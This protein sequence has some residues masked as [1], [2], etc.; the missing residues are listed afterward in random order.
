MVDTA[1]ILAGGRG[2]RLFP[3][4][5]DRPKALVPLMDRPLISWIILWLKKN[6]IKK[7]I[8]S[9]DYKKEVLMDYLGDGKRFGVNIVYN[10]HK[11]AKDTGDAFRNVFSNV[12]LPQT[13][14]AMNSD[15]ITDLPIKSLIAHHGASNH[16]ATI[17][18]VPTRI[19]Y[20]I[21]E[22]DAKHTVKTFTEKPLLENLLMN[23]GIYV[24][25]KDISKHL[26]KRGPIEKTTF[27]KLAKEGKLKVYVHRG[28]FT[29]V[30]S[31]RDLEESE[32]ILKESKLNFI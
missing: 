20:G 17:V 7:I 8:I 11:G 13:F 14:L 32:R 6:G 9:T 26:P 29:T 27:K 25:S 3:L 21:I 1:V 2:T 16:L 22:H 15:Q 24:F 10:D 30:N 23:T 31:H 28:L 5:A 18:A 12:R 19:P 4:T